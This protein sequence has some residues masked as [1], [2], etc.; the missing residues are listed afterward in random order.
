M[1][2]TAQTQAPADDMV[3]KLQKQLD[4][5]KKQRAT[6]ESNSIKQFQKPPTIPVDDISAEDILN[7]FSQSSTANNRRQKTNHNDLINDKLTGQTQ[8]STAANAQISSSQ[9]NSALQH[10]VG[11][12]ADDIS[13][14]DILN[15]FGKNQPSTTD[16]G[17]LDNM[18]QNPNDDQLTSKISND[19]QST[20]NAQQAINQPQIPTTN[21]Q[22]PTQPTG[23]M[24][25][26]TMTGSSQPETVHYQEIGA[27][28]D[29]DKEL[30]KWV[31]QVPDAEKITLPKPVAD[32][33]GKTLIEASQ[34][35]K[36]N[37]TLPL[38]ES[39]MQ[40]ALHHKIIDS[41][42]WLYE[43]AKRLIL[44]QPERVSYKEEK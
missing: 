11:D 38:S 23:S 35:P 28:L 7:A 27:E 33:Y 16:V 32:D 34:I 31:E 26:E 29:Q 43:W 10:D 20:F 30:E 37:I 14:E 15:A 3:V 25:K 1:D 39:E 24:H 21:Y 36:P 17:Q 12:E 6:E 44:L 8:P 41:F 2:I 22:L 5:L 9:V 4:Y 19:Q 18:K 40:K 13:T 42:L